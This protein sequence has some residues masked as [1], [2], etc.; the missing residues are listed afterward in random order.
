MKTRSGKGG[1][2]QQ[3]V[4]IYPNPTQGWPT[5]D[6][7]TLEEHSQI[8][9]VGLVPGEWWVG[10]LS[11]QSCDFDPD[12]LTPRVISGIS[13]FPGFPLK[14]TLQLALKLECEGTPEAWTEISFHFGVPPK[15]NTRQLHRR[16]PR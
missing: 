7:A 10:S 15:C 3:Q 4:R 11:M 12:F 14:T 13:H 2:G 16:W 9:A 6:G 5:C 1:G 8:S